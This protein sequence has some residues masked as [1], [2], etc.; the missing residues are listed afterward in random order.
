MIT[1]LV[2]Q[3]V[4]DAGDFQVTR[5]VPFKTTAAVK[6]PSPYAWSVEGLP[7]GNLMAELHW[8]LEQFLKRSI[9]NATSKESGLSK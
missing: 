1:N 8:Y 7:D 9:S 5:P 6:V 3:Q 2:I 4:S